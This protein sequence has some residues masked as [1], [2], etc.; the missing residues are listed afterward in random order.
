M[1]IAALLYVVF[2]AS[3]ASAWAGVGAN[4]SAV[5]SGIAFFQMLA[6]LAIVIGLLLG[7]AFLMRRLNG[8][9]AFGQAGP[10]RIVAQ[11]MI[12]ARERVVLLEVGEQW[13][14][15]GVVPGQI[16]TLHTLP[17][18]QLA[19]AD[20]NA[21]PPFARWLKHFSERPHAEN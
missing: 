9:R 6:G 20:S 16:K 3:A 17:K 2:L 11:L 18:G 15:V 7:T 5:T 12:S 19:A 21:E 13:I 1:F 8:G 10:M 14:V 4:D